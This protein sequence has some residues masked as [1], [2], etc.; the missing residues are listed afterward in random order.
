MIRKLLKILLYSGA[1]LLLLALAAYLARNP[2][3]DALARGLSAVVSSSLQGSLHIGTLRGTLLTSLIVQDVVVRDEQNNVVAQVDAVR[4][5]YNPLLL[6][7]GQLLISRVRLIRP[8]LTLIQHADGS[9]NIARL[10]PPAP[11]RPAAS[12]EAPTSGLT[13]PFAVVVQRVR[14]RDGAIALQTAALPGV[15]RIDGLQMRLRGSFTP[16]GMRLTLRQL[17]ARALPAD[18]ELRTV[19]AALRGSNG[20][21]RLDDLRLQT[22]TTL[23]TADGVL[24]GGERPARFALHMQPLD[25]TEIGRL[26]HDDT[27]HG[28]LHVTLKAEG[29]PEAL[30]VRTH[31]QAHTGR[32][33]IQSQLNLATT[34][35]HY[36]GALE[37][38]RFDLAALLRRPGVQSDLNLR[39]S[40]EGQGLSPTTM[41]GHV[42]CDIAPS[43]VGDISL[44]PSQIQIV[45]RPQQL[46]VRRLHLDT[47]VA[48]MTASGAIRLDDQSDL[49]Y[50]LSADLSQL[51]SLVRTD[52]VGGTLRLQGDVTG[53]FTA[54][55]ARGTL[56]A[57]KLRL[58]AY[59]LQALSLTYEG[60]QLRTHP[61]VTAR[62]E[63]QQARAGTIVLERLAGE[64]TYDDAARQVRFTHRVRH[65][66]TTSGEMQGVVSLTPTG[67]EIVLDTLVVRLDKRMWRAPQPVEVA[68]APGRVQ[69]K[70]FRIEHAEEAL[71]L[72]GALDG[73]QFRNLRVAATR[74]DLTALRKHLQLPELVGGRAGF[75][76]DLTGTFAQP[77]LQGELSL[78]PTA[79]GELPFE[80]L[81]TTLR[82]HDKTFRS[83][84][85]VHQEGRQTLALQLHLPL[86]MALTNLSLPQRLI[87]APVTL[88]VSLDRPALAALH[89][90]QAAL[91]PLAGTLKGTLDLRGTYAA[92]T[93]AMQLQL[94]RLGIWNVIDDVEAPVQLTAEVVT[95][96]SVQAFGEMLAQ[97]QLLPILRKL[98][99]RVPLVRA[100]LP[101]QETPARTIEV[102]ELLLQ[103]DGR[104]RPEGLEATL[105]TLRLQAQ[106]LTF[107]P[108]HLTLAGRVTPQ[109]AELTTMHVRLPR[110][111]IHGRGT[112][113]FDSQQVQLHVEL[114]RVQLTEFVPTFPTT[115]P[116]D[117]RGTVDVQGTLQELSMETRLRYAGG[118]LVAELVAQVQQAMPRYAL[119]VRVADLDAARLLPEAQGR[120]HASLRLHGAGLTGEARQARLA[121]R[122]TSDQFT[123]LPGL[124]TQLDAALQGEAVQME[125]LQVQ[126]TPLTLQARGGLSAERH[127]DLTYSL[128]L[129]DL[130]PLQPLLGIPVQAQGDLTGELQGALTDLQAKGRVQLH[131]LGIAAFQG[132][133][134][135]A[136]FSATRLFAEPH[137]ALNLRLTEFHGPSLPTTSLALDATFQAPRGTFTVDVTKGPYTASRLAGTLILQ[138][139]A[140][141]TLTQLRVQSRDVVWENDGPIEAVRTP[142]G[143]IELQPLLLRRGEQTLS[144]QGG[145]TP[146]GAVTA[147][148]HLQH[149][150][151][152]S[153]VQAVAPY[154]DIPDGRLA[155]ELSLRGTVA[156]PHL[157]GN[158]AL[159]SLQWRGEQLGEVRSTFEMVSQSLRLDLRWQEQE[160]EL[161]HAHGTLG[162]GPAG[163]LALQVQAPALDLQ[164]LAPLSP[165]V[166]ESAGSLTLDVRLTGTL[167]Q[168]LV[169]GPLEVRDGVLRLAVAGE[170]Y[171]DMQ[172]R[173]LFRGERVDIAR[174][175][176]GSRSGPLEV[177]GY[178]E[179][180]GRMLRYVELAVRAHDFTAV[181]TTEMQAILSATVDV[182]GSLE[183]MAVRGKVKVP[184]GRMRL[185]DKLTGGPTGVEPWELT[186]AGAYGSGPEER[187]PVDGTTPVPQKPVPL[188]F[189]RANLALDIPRNVWVQGPGTAVEMRGK[190]RVTKELRAPFILSGSIETVRGFATFYGKKFV[191]EQGL[192]TFPG[193]EEINPILDV[194]S[195]YTVS[196]YTISMHVE[197]KA[198]QPQLTLSSPSHPELEQHNIVSLLVLGKTTDRL[199]SSEQKS[200]SSQAQAVAGGVLA[201]QLEKTVGKGLGLDVIEVNAGD[202][203]TPGSVSVGRYV[204][205]DIFLSYER[206]FVE[207]GGNKVGVEYN[208]K[209]NLKLKGSSS[210]F[211][212]TS[213]DLLWQIDY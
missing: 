206:R 42:Q 109:Q 87:D 146:A 143:G 128:R 62:L 61:R 175:H 127:V 194:V 191:V 1:A 145:L 187:T 85:Q 18:V 171:R 53:P 108:A 124:T 100:Q 110:S 56:Q 73:E 84:T 151:L 207:A 7:Q 119:T 196:D 213:L 71:E 183:D 160:A 77:L 103:G 148:V 4:L 5:G 75:S 139:G 34:P 181:H 81:V 115:L 211:G 138:A 41:H 74:I 200:L 153:T 25:V 91:P 155:L 209:R 30:Q 55:R 24:P 179:R 32:I 3:R 123:L 202:G 199:T 201:D 36:T 165:Q 105:H 114:P 140:Q 178:V 131:Q 142:Q 78:R 129:G 130:Q 47:S 69:I 12:P 83:Q 158:M 180:A 40:L 144:V 70:R 90:W 107:P 10:V 51:R 58:Q 172:V 170:R 64:A 198:Q 156:Q 162:M 60:T 28:N 48:Q 195:T 192:V 52:A 169:D 190:L 39:L 174:C 46:Q 33:D 23:I 212:E 168:P 22:A 76:L 21:W 159:T 112:V 37:V 210:D 96:E 2:V 72:G 132:Q 141:L 80:R 154:T 38:D 50:Q 173:L 102:R 137:A 29:A 44:R 13:L 57:A 118:R 189:V 14:I 8:R 150:H 89:R 122:L 188:P 95:A 15:Q 97:G 63:A 98:E 147:A 106:A 86:D 120:L 93:L 117:V 35:V 66:S 11:P 19:R 43:H 99:A 17:T 94:Q 135:Q 49:R 161:V 164:K 152:R 208:L 92:L 6:L 20:T 116:P 193:T 82:Y 121:L 185:P 134:V 125:K 27:L 101:G 133:A 167:A 9:W 197:G 104:W 177:T 186:V 204:T 67:Q 176:I 59:G 31:V 45:A 126:S 113:A 54:L 149:L 79:P 65:S 26:L 136:D 205:Q 184:R 166:H 163:V 157:E 68:L 111:E 203:L 182:K 16:R 88:Q